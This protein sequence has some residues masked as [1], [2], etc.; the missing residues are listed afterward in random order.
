MYVSFISRSKDSLGGWLVELPSQEHKAVQSTPHCNSLSQC[1][2]L[3]AINFWEAE[4][5][6]VISSPKVK[7]WKRIFTMSLKIVDNVCDFTPHSHT[8]YL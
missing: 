6:N 4:C 8:P 3:R 1:V 7:A 2:K 5:Q